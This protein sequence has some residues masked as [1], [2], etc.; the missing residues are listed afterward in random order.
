MLRLADLLVPCRRLSQ[1]VG[2][3][4]PWDRRVKVICSPPDL[5]AYLLASDDGRLAERHTAGRDTRSSRGDKP[6]I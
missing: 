5:V 3:H 6:I 1:S 4:V 2:F